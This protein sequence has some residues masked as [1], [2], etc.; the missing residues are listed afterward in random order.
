MQKL[1]PKF[2][3]TRSRMDRRLRSSIPLY[4]EELL[5]H[6]KQSGY[7]CIVGHLFCGALWYADDVSILAPSLYA[8]RQMCDICSDYGLKYNLQFNP[9][10]CKLLN[11]SQYRD[12]FFSISN[13]YVPVVDCCKHLGH[14]IGSSTRNT[15][16]RDAAH[17]LV[18]RVNGVLSNFSQCNMLS[19][20]FIQTFHILLHLMLW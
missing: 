3:Y 12:V 4:I 16:Y 17:D 13:E 2:R 15:L 7:G 18:R 14:F 9:T 19:R 20:C 11:F 5:S 1:G 10:K 6:L 8:L